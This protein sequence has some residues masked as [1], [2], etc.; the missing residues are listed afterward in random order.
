MPIQTVIG[1]SDAPEQPGVRVDN[2]CLLH[3]DWT[4]EPATSRPAGEIEEGPIGSIDLSLRVLHELTAPSGDAVR[5]VPGGPASLGWHPSPPLWK[6]LASLLQ[7]PTDLLLAAAGPIEWP[8][9]LFPYQVDAVR[10]LLAREAILLADDTGLGKTVEAIA[11]LRILV[12][13][14]RMQGALLVVPA[15]LVRQWRKAITTWAPELQVSTIRGPAAE[16]AW[17]WQSPAHVY[18][19]SYDT[20]REDGAD[21]PDSPS[22]RRTWD[23]V[24]LDEAQRIK[25]RDAGV[26]RLCKRL[27]R[28]R[29]WALT[30]TPLENNLDD[31]ASILEFV[32][33]STDGPPTRLF[34][35]PEVIERQRAVQLRR[36][37]V[38]VMPQLPPKLT[39]TITLQLGVEQRASYER[40]ER[41]GVYALKARGADVQIRNVLE[42][43]TRL[44]Q[45][46]NVD[47]VSGHSAKFADLHVRLTTLVSE[48][49]RALVFTQ[50]TD[51]TFGARAIAARLVRL[52]PLLYTGDMSL[53]QRDDVIRN[54]KEDSSHSVLVLSLR[55]GGVGL[56]LQDASYVFHFDR[57]WNPSVELQ[58]EDRSHRLGQA[59]PVN[60]YTYMCEQ[61]VEERIEV[62][63]RRKRRLFQDVVDEVSLD[64]ESLLTSAE[65]FSLFGLSIPTTGRDPRV[66]YQM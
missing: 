36:R 1:E 2:A 12:L 47:A 5:R 23:V 21:N 10:T 19:I 46:C 38:D 65:L 52:R 54:F 4:W 11:A 45:L 25:N 41:D 17:Q 33:P 28:R 39:S 42:L 57:W 44:K 9:A 20:L 58:A 13:Q 64:L 18:L 40:A 27:R 56:N 66:R 24:A 63:L 49:H 26:S 53:S 32:A 61:T 6:R 16:R 14:R 22:R 30:G 34:S 15:G 59:Y 48:G 3:G 37:K 51:A 35:G 29:A 50:F 62:V 43:I 60:V 55:A 8:A 7:P 31:L